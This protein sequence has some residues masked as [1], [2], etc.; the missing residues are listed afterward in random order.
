MSKNVGLIS[1]ILKGVESILMIM[2]IDLEDYGENNVDTGKL[3]KNLIGCTVHRFSKGT[4]KHSGTALM[5]TE[6]PGEE[7]GL[8]VQ[9]QMKNNNIPVT[10]VRNPKSWKGEKEK[11]K[12]DISELNEMCPMN[13]E[14]V[15]QKDIMDEDS[16]RVLFIF[17]T[18]EYIGIDLYINERGGTE[19]FETEL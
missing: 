10:P 7:K 12:I 2:S 5:V 16:A 13:I 9:V 19:F 4:G 1:L 14:D 6:L 11:T 3:L 17:E 15:V 8:G 18:D